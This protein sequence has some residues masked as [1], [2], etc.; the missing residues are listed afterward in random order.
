MSKRAGK[1][2]RRRK[3]F[4]I[5]SY[6]PTTGTSHV[7]AASL[8]QPT[9]VVL[10]LPRLAAMTLAAV[11]D[12]AENLSQHRGHRALPLQSPLPVMRPA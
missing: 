8:A 3:R 6:T 7:A 5:S 10:V 12:V 4:D 1:D 2:L 9:V 11:I